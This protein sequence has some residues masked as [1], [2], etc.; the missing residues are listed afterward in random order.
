MRCGENAYKLML[1]K[2]FLAGLLAFGSAVSLRAA[3]SDL[4]AAGQLYVKGMGESSRGDYQNAAK[5]FDQILTDY[6]S[7]QSIDEIRLESGIAHLHEKDFDG[8]VSTLAKLTA[9]TG[10]AEYRAAALYYT[11]YA[12]LLKGGNAQGDAGKPA[13]QAAVQTLTTLINYIIK[14]P[15]PDNNDYLELAYYNRGLA[16]MYQDDITNSVADVNQLLKQ[17]PASL[18][19]PDYLLLL[20]N[21]YARQAAEALQAK[22]MDVV[23]SSSDQ[24]IQALDQAINDP[25]AR[26]QA[27]DAQLAKAEVLYLIAGL[28]P[29]DPS[30]FQ[31]SLDEFRLVRRKDDLIPEQQATVDALRK[32]LQAEVAASGG[33]TMDKKLSEV[34]DREDARLQQLKTEPDPII[35]ALIR[36]AQ[37]YNSMT[38]GNEARTVLHRLA[39][40]PLAPDQQQQIML[41]LINSYVLAH[42]PDKANTAMDAYMLK[43]KDDPAAQGVSIEIGN[44]LFKR[45]DFKGALDQALRSRKDFPNGAYVDQAVT[46][47]VQCYTALN[48]PDKANEVTKE[49]ESSH[50]GGSS[51]VNLELSEAERK[52]KAGDLAGALAD[53]QDVRDKGGTPELQQSAD[54]GVMQTMQA[55]GKLDD[56]INEADTFQGKW[57]TSSLLSNVLV[58]KGVAQ[59]QKKDPAWLKTLQDEAAQFPDDNQ[60]SPTP[61][62]LY[63][64]VNHYQR[65][66]EAAQMIQA[67]DALRKAF[68]TRYDLVMQAADAVSDVYQKAGKYDDAIAFYQPLADSAPADTASV[69]AA[70]IALVLVAK[71]KAAGQHYQS[72]DP[73]KRADLEKQLGD[74]ETALVGVL[75]KYP[76]QLTA[77]DDAFTGLEE[78]MKVRHSWGILKPA[79]YE[80]YLAKQT[81]DLT[82]PGMKTRVELA[83]AGLVFDE[84]HGEDHY[85]DALARFK[86]ATAAAPSLPLTRTEASRY[87]ELLLSAKD[88]P[89]ALNVY[90]ALLA[91]KPDDPQ[92]A[93]D[94]YYGLGA[95]YFAQG[96]LANAKLN[97]LKMKKLNASWS[98][99][100]MDMQYG[101]AYA[102]E[103]SSDP[104]D[105]DAAKS[106]YNDIISDQSASV[107]LQSKATLGYGRLLEKA[108]DA[109]NAIHYY[110]QVATIFGPAVAALSAEGLYDAGQLYDKN[111]DKANAIKAYQQIESDYGPGLPDWD[112]KAKA[113]LQKDGA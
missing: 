15:T 29:Q 8:T 3:N 1:V 53:Y 2:W 35:Q 16:Y 48:Q 56:L 76:D 26:V 58:M 4:D 108:G 65:T 110:M 24:A 40:A 87:G 73:A 102:N 54:A 67:A 31:K 96:D 82:D 44:E 74:A 51:V 6:P 89:T 38:D 99:H 5:D 64:I 25:N 39:K 7:T 111:N 61:F 71:V 105:Q 100:W 14:N 101:L 92:V 66:G 47:E 80:D 59:E 63:F 88:Y 94:A 37:C 91:T 18:T 43:Y 46:L 72:S 97:F 106:A 11:A 84:K 34:I 41:A 79:D 9:D 36:I 17:F 90:N 62:A 81:A 60:N 77:V 50:S 109:A 75:K 45:G 21:L 28:T 22:K 103:N 85:A 78:T 57:P 70:K 33:K 20:G 12:Q 95:T 86:A 93:A 52:A 23:H 113:A 42:Q 13:L 27:N 10:P 104:G 68:P 69:A 30:G 83:K 49:W 112:A 107:E 32:Q 19:R 98:P 55:M